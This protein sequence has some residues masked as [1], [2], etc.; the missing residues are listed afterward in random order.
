MSPCSLCVENPSMSVP[1]VVVCACSNYDKL[2]ARI[3]KLEHTLF[4]VE[5]P[6]SCL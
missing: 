4:D 5:N 1:N 3:K 6:P 2:N